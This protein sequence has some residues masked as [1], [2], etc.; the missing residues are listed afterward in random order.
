MRSRLVFSVVVVFG[1]LAAF[2][3]APVGSGQE[4]IPAVVD[5]APAAGAETVVYYFHGNV[6]CATCKKIEAYADE[7]VHEEFGKALEDGSLQWQVVNIDE[8]ENRHF[9]QDF[10]LVTKSV[11]LVEYRDGKVVRFKNLDQVWQLVRDKERFVTYV[12]DATREFL[13][14]G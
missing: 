2:L 7:A 5:S 6:R 1:G 11:V 12:Q 13:A 10:Q 9:I 8:P 4:A 3:T 14:A